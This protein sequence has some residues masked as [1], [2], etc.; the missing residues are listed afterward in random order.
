MWVK[1]SSSGEFWPSLDA[2]EKSKI[3]NFVDN[4]KEEKSCKMLQ[5]L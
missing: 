5:T 3:K 1:P 2:L 4:L